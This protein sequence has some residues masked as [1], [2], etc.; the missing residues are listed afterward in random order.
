MI[1]PMTIAKSI[2]PEAYAV[3]SHGLLRQA[4]SVGTIRIK[5]LI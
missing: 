2:N 1:G 3:V 5:A 4:F